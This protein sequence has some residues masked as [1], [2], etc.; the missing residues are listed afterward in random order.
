MSRIVN[1][2]VSSRS[3]IITVGKK[4]A[5]GIVE[6]KK[7]AGGDMEEISVADAISKVIAE[8]NA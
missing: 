4:A 7:R 6:F 1:S 2:A 3:F 8:V 5:E